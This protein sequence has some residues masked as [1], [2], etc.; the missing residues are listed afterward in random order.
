M[1]EPVT[2]MFLLAELEEVGRGIQEAVAL[3]APITG[4]VDRAEE[5]T[6]A[7]GVLRVRPVWARHLSRVSLE[8]LVEDIGL[9]VRQPYPGPTMLPPT[10]EEKHDA[11]LVLEQGWDGGKD[12]PEAAN[13]MLVEAQRIMDESS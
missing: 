9:P 6:Q 11:I 8:R 3:G 1:S 2:E 12:W 10:D 4:L 13:A 7:L 5:L